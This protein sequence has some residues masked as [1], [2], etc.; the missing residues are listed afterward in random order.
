MNKAH[1][2]LLHLACIA[3]KLTRGQS[4]AWHWEHVLRE[5]GF[6]DRFERQQARELGHKIAKFHVIPHQ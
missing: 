3:I 6:R 1:R 2:C 4:T 5:F